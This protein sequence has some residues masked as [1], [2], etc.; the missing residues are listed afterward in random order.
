[1]KQSLKNIF[2]DMTYHKAILIT[3]FLAI[4]ANLT[5]IIPHMITVINTGFIVTVILFCLHITQ[6]KKTT[7]K[8][9]G[10]LFTDEELDIIQNACL[11]NI[12][13]MP[14]IDE[15]TIN[16]ICGSEYENWTMDAKFYFFTNAI[17][18]LI[19]AEQVSKNVTEIL[20]K[21]TLPVE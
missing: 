12:K 17:G 9:E 10:R 14:P 3:V 8:D 7:S 1:M 6:V 15:N 5:A 19:L 16:F 2:S 18:H 21:E 13:K 11:R 4:G 20:Q